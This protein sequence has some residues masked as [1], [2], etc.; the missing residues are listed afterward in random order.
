MSNRI[1]CALLT[2]AALQCSAQEASRAPTDGWKRAELKSACNSPVV[3]VSERA[4]A[5]L[6]TP[7]FTEVSVEVQVEVEP[8]GTLGK[9]SIKRT[10][11]YAEFD[12]IALQAYV[13]FKCTFPEPL[14]QPFVG[15][16]T[17]T[18]RKVN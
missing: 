12:E 7:S 8:P 16:Q 18:F 6:R 1:A 2:S 5:I 3:K 4:M 11:G 17:L 9:V 15:L 14:T 13:G 10:S